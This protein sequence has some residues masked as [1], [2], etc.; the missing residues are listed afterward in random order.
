MDSGNVTREQFIL[1]ALRG[2]KSDLKPELG[3]A[4]VDQQ[5]A[6]RAYLE[7]KVDLGALSAVQYGM[8]NVPNAVASMALYDGTQDSVAAAIDAI[9][10][11]YTAALDPINGEFLIQVT[12]VLDSPFIA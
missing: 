3:Q 1:E 5:L 12:G 9:N 2:A 6:D 4:F 11:H 7:T 8:S 10:G